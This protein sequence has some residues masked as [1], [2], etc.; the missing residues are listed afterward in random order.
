M[1]ALFALAV[2]CC[3]VTQVAASDVLMRW[4]DV[5][6]NWDNYQAWIGLAIWQVMGWFAPILAGPLK[7]IAIDLW[8]KVVKADTTGLVLPL[9]NALGFAGAGDFVVPL[10][11]YLL[12][13]LTSLVPMLGIKIDLSD[14]MVAKLVKDPSFLTTK[15][16]S[17]PSKCGITC[18][19]FPTLSFS[20]KTCADFCATTP[21]HNM[22]L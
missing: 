2:A 11:Y 22:C 19:R 10:F 1:K 4:L 15:C 5:I 16:T 21:A 13:I 12:D 3:L 18:T 17:D 6:N 8:A 9:M 7:V 20:G 14:N